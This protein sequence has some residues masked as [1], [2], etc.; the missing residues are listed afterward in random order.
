MMDS[1]DLPCGRILREEVN[2]Q[3]SVTKTLLSLLC[4]YYLLCI[5]GDVCCFLSVDNFIG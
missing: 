1:K 4:G 3:I 2:D 5:C